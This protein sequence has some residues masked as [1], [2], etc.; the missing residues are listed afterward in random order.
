MQ[1]SQLEQLR[2]AN[3]L[4]AKTFQQAAINGDRYTGE[5]CLLQLRKMYREKQLLEAQQP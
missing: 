1:N 2:E 4:T 3:N 5:I